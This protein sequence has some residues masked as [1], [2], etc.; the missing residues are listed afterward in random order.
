MSQAE[1]AEKVYREFEQFVG[2]QF[3]NEVD[4]L[5]VAGVMMAQALKIYKTALADDEFDRMLDAILRSREEITALEVPVI[6]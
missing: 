5:I 2:Q 6:H 4:P 1:L 3:S